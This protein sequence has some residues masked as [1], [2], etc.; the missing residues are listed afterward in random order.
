MKISEKNVEGAPLPAARICTDEVVGDILS[1]WRYDISGVSPEMRTDYESHLVECAHC[2]RRQTIHRTV[3]VALMVLSTLSILAFLLAAAIIHRIEPLAHLAFY[4][5][6]IRQ[7]S[8]AITMQFA[9]VAGLLFSTL[10]WVLVAI[11]TPAPVFLNGVVRERM[12][13]ELRERFYKNA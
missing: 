5:L 10:C 3:D 6:H 4:N 8:I 9:A 7:I 11:M 12:P 13:E 1:G 2:H